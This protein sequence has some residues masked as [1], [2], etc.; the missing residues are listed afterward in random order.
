MK[1][2]IWIS[3]AVA[4]VLLLAGSRLAET[5]SYLEFQRRAAGEA[6]S[7]VDSALDRRASLA[8]RLVEAVRLASR[9]PRSGLSEITQ[10]SLALG[11][12]HSA[13]GRMEAYARLDAALSTVLIGIAHDP[14]FLPVETLRR[15]RDELASAENLIAI[16]RRKY[17][18]AVQKYNTSIEL[19]PNNI[20]ASLFGFARID[21]YFQTEPAGRDLPQRKL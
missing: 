18:D 1:G 14:E 21:A 3:L 13:R 12:V 11:E 7:E 8:L 5:R 16:K 17:N 20:A 15:L 19:F 9:Q 6:W 2:V 4:A 10:A